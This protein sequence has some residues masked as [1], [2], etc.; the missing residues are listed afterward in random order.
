M[1]EKQRQKYIDFLDEYKKYVGLSDWKIFVVAEPKEMES[2]AEVESNI[3]EKE[4]QVTLS[5][6][7]FKVTNARRMNILFHELVHARVDIGQLKAKHA[8]DIEE[9]QIVNDIVRGFECLKIF[10]F[11]GDKNELAKSIEQ[12]PE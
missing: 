9:E 10:K 3:Y 11:K 6:Q 1:K 5:K 2:L 12:K 8:V 7:F 4:M